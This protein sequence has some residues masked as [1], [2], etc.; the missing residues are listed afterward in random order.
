MYLTV[1]INL[2]SLHSNLKPDESANQ[3]PITN[4]VVRAKR[5]N[6]LVTKSPPVEPSNDAATVSKQ[7]SKKLKP[8]T[9]DKQTEQPSSVE[10]L[11]TQSKTITEPV[12]AETP[13]VAAPIRRSL[14][15]TDTPAV[16]SLPVTN[17]GPPSSRRSSRFVTQ[18]EWLISI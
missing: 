12:T 1:S 18:S 2:H 7:N 16:V 6:D 5:K 3:E 4:G 11:L 15:Y 17:G 9:K 10:S 14:V 13:Y 8:T